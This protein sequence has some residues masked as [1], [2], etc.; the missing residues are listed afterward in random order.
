M[1]PFPRLLYIEA[2]EEITDL[3]D[4]LRELDEE[5][6]VT[7]V[8]PERARALQS[9][10]SFK[11]LRRYADSY[12]KR[13]NII[14]SEPR[15]QTL[16]LDAGF[17][18]YDSLDAYE[19]GAPSG[20]SSREGNGHVA[21]EPAPERAPA[22]LATAVREIPRPTISAP[23]RPAGATPIPPPGPRRPRRPALLVGAAAAVLLGLIG[24]MVLLPS[25]TVVMSVTG[26]PLSADLQLSGS[27]DAPSGVADRFVTQ[28]V[29][30]TETQTAST[31]ATGQQPVPAVAAQGEA[32]FTLTCF[33]CQ[34]AT[35]PR[36]LTVRT[37]DGKRYATQQTGTISGPSGSTTVPIK[38]VAVGAVGNTDANT[39]STIEGNTHPDELKVNNP[40]AVSGGADARTATVVQQSDIDAAKQ[41]LLDQLNPKV[42]D[43]L[44]S[45][46]KGAH[47]LPVG[48]PQVQLTTD[49]K[50]K[51]EASSFSVTVSVTQSGVTFDN[52]AVQKLLQDALRRKVPAG[53]ELTSDRIHTSYDVAQASPD[54]DLTLRGHADGF[55]VPIFSREQL[56]ARL[57][58]QSPSHA[59]ALL[60]GQ[61]DV[62][63]VIVRQ[64]PFGLPWLPFFSSR[65]TVQIQE[66]PGTGSSGATP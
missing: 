57:K 13:V 35:L 6:T 19:G 42:E 16:S 36:G 14:S 65:I 20:A 25:A 53:Q 62:V 34:G 23:P 58:G 41:A 49:H 52:G 44:N 46:A 43:D 17:T 61:P 18:A 63:D 33:L 37:P 40:V 4:R 30:A 11:L 45:K 47:L 38:A 12:G 3:V 56:R 27:T 48:Q 26:A 24:A 64:Q 59:R 5:D 22:A 9:P 66:V 39:I 60:L 21:I 1:K 55:A 8:V 32:V 2:D 15:L 7:F 31:Q 50:V 51:D 29:D 10:M 28:V 54:G